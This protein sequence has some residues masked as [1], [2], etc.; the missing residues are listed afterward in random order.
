[1]PHQTAGRSAAEEPKKCSGGPWPEPPSGAD[2]LG[3]SGTLG[4]VT[5]EDV[6]AK[7]MI[8]TQPSQLDYDTMGGKGSPQQPAW[9]P[10]D[11]AA[12]GAFMEAFS[13]RLEESGELVETRALA[14]PVRTR[15]IQLQGRVPVTTDGPYAETQ[16]VPAGYRIVDR[17]SFDWATGIAAE[18]ANCPAPS[19][20]RAP[21][22]DVRPVVES[23]VELEAQPA[24]VSHHELEGL[25]RPL[26]PQVLGAVVRRYGHF[27]L[28]EDAT[29]ETLAAATWPARGYP[30]NTKA[31]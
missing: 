24:D 22:A 26:A 11:F 4:A 27:D 25:L 31:C 8:L 3:R 21:F 10:A 23:R 1:M 30:D 17:A 2:V 12:L 14:P 5:Q 29:Q 19:G 13:K 9:A 28:A 7:Y 15:R 20:G 16:E 18:L 6:I